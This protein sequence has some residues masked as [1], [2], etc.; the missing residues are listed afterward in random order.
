MLSAIRHS[1]NASSRSPAMSRH[2]HPTMMI[3]SDD[4]TATVSIFTMSDSSS[5]CREHMSLSSAESLNKTDRPFREGT[6]VIYNTSNNRHAKNR[7]LL[8]PSDPCHRL[9]R[10]KSAFA[11]TK[12]RCAFN[13]LKSKAV[14]KN[15]REHF[16]LHTVYVFASQFK[17]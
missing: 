16:S 17:T 8:L 11:S 7:I 9:I 4:S 6:V 1:N 5:Q 14:Y 10:R 13:L 15:T 2:V 12:V 3:D